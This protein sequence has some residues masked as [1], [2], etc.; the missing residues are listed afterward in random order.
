LKSAIPIIGTAPM[1]FGHCFF[2]GTSP[3]EDT[4]RIDDDVAASFE[5]GWKPAAQCDAVAL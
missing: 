1:A 3:I 2:G 5:K 4:N